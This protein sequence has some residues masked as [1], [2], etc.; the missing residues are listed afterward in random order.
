M[1]PLPR[2]DLEQ[3]KNSFYLKLNTWTLVNQTLSGHPELGFHGS[4]LIETDETL[5]LFGGTD[6]LKYYDN[7]YAYDE[8]FGFY[9]T[10]F[11]LRVPRSDMAVVALKEN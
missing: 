4:G 3:I 1:N 2:M 8:A 11:K 5:I 6:G 10:G 9:D 7:V